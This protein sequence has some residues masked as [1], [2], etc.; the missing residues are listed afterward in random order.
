MLLSA[1]RLLQFEHIRTKRFTTDLRGK[2]KETFCQTLV[3]KERF[4][5]RETSIALV[6]NWFESIKKAIKA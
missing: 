4:P 6:W 3:S 1:F 5:L 2:I